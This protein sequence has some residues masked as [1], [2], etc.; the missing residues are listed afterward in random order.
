MLSRCHPGISAASA[1]AKARA[2]SRSLDHLVGAGEQCRWHLELAGRGRDD[3][4]ARQLQLFSCDFRKSFAQI[5]G[6]HNWQELG[7]GVQTEEERLDC[8][9]D[10][11]RL[12]HIKKY[13]AG[14]LAVQV[15]KVSRLWF[16]FAQ[17]RFH[18]ASE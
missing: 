2:R 16:E 6:I 1:T 14:A 13:H 10:L 18:R 8:L 11:R 15:R 12:G 7:C 17:D 9:D 3:L 5:V 4:Q